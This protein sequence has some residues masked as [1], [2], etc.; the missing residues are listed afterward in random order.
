MVYLTNILL[1]SGPALTLLMRS[2]YIVLG[3]TFFVLTVFMLFKK[4]NRMWPLDQSVKWMSQGFWVYA[5]IAIF[6]HSYHGQISRQIETFLPMLLYPLLFFVVPKLPLRT[7]YLWTGAATGAIGAGLVAIY[8][9]KVLGVARADGF[10]YNPIPFGDIALVLSAASLIALLQFPLG[11]HAK[12]LKVWLAFGGAFGMIASLLSGTRGGWLT[13]LTLVLFS[14]WI[15]SSNWS[16]WKRWIALLMACLLIATAVHLSPRA[17]VMDRIDKGLSGGVTWIKTGQVTDGSVSLRLALFAEGFSMFTERP[18]LGWEW[19][20]VKAEQER[21]LLAR[22]VDPVWSSPKSYG[23]FEN[24]VIDKLV[25]FGLMG[26]ISVVCAFVFPFWAF[27]R[28]RLDRDAQIRCFA[29]MGMLLP[30]M[31]M[32]FGLSV[33]VLSL[34]AMR[35]V[36]V[37]WCVILM[38]LILHRQ[39][40][41]EAT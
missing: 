13:L 37:A 1:F 21:R 23:A 3:L 25:G 5:A 33:S 35:R 10:Y 14:A 30:I 11:K 36:Y 4:E 27:W 9:A 32:E 38:C 6:I 39:R 20:S 18:I 17:N 19:R 22:G 16:H 12:L 8:Q 31:F 26:L 29:T 40:E 34:N 7:H 24:E 2:G 41:L 28:Y 15:L